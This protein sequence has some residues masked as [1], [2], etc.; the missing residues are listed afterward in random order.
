[1][2][3]KGRSHQWQKSARPINAEKGRAK[4][5]ERSHCVV[6]YTDDPFDDRNFEL[7]RDLGKACRLKLVAGKPLTIDTPLFVPVNN[8]FRPARFQL[9]QVPG[10]ER[11]RHLQ[12]ATFKTSLLPLSQRRFFRK[13]ASHS[14]MGQGEYLFHVSTGGLR[15]F[16]SATT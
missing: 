8:H 15:R 16:G 7:K 13:L 6:W 4:H 12:P 14:H 10:F 1:M 3:D 5:A 9:H 11:L 2:N